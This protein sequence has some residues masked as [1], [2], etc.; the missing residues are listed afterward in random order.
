MFHRNLREKETPPPEAA[1]DQAVPPD[2]DIIGGVLPR[3]IN[4]LPA[5]VI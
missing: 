2:L 5:I 1:N 4:K 3:A